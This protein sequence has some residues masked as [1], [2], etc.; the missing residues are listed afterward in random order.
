MRIALK[1]PTRGRP[2][3][4]FKIVEHW[5]NYLSGQHQCQFIVSFDQNDTT[6]NDPSVISRLSK[7][8]DVV[9]R[10]GNN[11]NKIAAVNA[12]MDLAADWDFLIL[13]SD[14]M[15]PVVRGYDDLI[16]QHMQ[17]HFPYL[18]GCLWY[19][20]GYRTD[21]YTLSIIGRK[22][23]DAVGYIYHPD[24][25]SLWADNHAQWLAGE[26][27]KLAH[28]PTVPVRHEWV[29]ITGKDFTHC[30]NSTSEIFAADK[31]VFLRLRS[32]GVPDSVRAAL[33]KRDTD[34]SL[35]QAELDSQRNI[36]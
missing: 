32:M 36:Q 33:P 9:F 4:F 12:D 35:T 23:Y 31:E 29:N 7:M 26:L 20:D 24:F 28:I 22:F 18:D 30:R 1:Y 11:K 34:P 19:D 2:K 21:L 8:S 15:V 25:N 3:L 10:C 6:M 14:D 13:V 27:G 5:R 16:A 17:Q